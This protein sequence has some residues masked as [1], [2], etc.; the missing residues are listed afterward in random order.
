MTPRIQEMLTDP[1]KSITLALSTENNP[2]PG[3]DCTLA[4]SLF[5]M[6]AQPVQN[7]IAMQRARYRNQRLVVIADDAW[8]NTTGVP[9]LTIPAGQMDLNVLAAIRERLARTK[10]AKDDA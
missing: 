4:T 10:E 7:W 9:S 2:V 1:I 6:H 8:R 3:I 5:I